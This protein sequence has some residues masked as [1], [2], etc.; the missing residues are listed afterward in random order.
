MQ[1]MSIIS[2]VKAQFLTYNLKCVNIL[3]QNSTSKYL[4]AIGHASI[5][6]SCFYQNQHLIA[7][8]KREKLKLAT[9]TQQRTIPGTRYYFRN[10]LTLCSGSGEGIHYRINSGDYFWHIV[11]E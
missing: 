10:L 5:D 1:G 3:Q 9:C 11:P 7:S 6:L 4:N 8:T 2:N